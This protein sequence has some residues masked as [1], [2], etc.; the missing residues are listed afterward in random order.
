MVTDSTEDALPR[1]ICVA[2]V[3]DVDGRRPERVDKGGEFLL[4]VGRAGGG[5]EDV[6]GGV[7][8]ESRVVVKRVWKGEKREGNEDTVVVAEAN[9]F[10]KMT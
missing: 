3:F 6:V 4:H 1:E 9:N 10:L 7:V 5:E 2:D 8:E